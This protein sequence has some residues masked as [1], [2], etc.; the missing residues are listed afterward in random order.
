[1]TTSMRNTD[2]RNVT[3]IVV[4][5]FKLRTG[6]SNKICSVLGLEREQLV[7]DFSDSVIKSFEKDI[8]P[9]YF[10]IDAISRD[11]ILNHSSEIAK[12]L[13]DLN[14]QLMIIC[15]GTYIRHQKSQ[16]NEYQ[17]KSYS[18]QTN[19]HYASHL[20]FARPMDTL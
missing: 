5:L 6:N 11:T 17:R 2:T 15:D 14:D 4:F 9:K 20:P 3:A 19:F 10:G 16:N 13:F 12:I 7:S 1:M 18:G 8:L